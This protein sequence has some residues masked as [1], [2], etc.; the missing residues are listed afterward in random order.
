M[1]F[2]SIPISLLLL[3]SPLAAEPLFNQK[4][5]GG[6]RGVGGEAKNWAVGD[7]GTLTCTGGAGAQWLATEKE[8]DDFDLS[9]EFKLPKNANSGVFVRAPGEGHPWVQGMEIQLL[10]DYGEKWKDLKPAQ[11][12]GSIYAV[13]APKERATKMAGEWQKLRVRCVGRSCKVWVNG[14]QVIDANLDKLAK[15]SGEKVPGL[16]RKSGMIGLQ[17]HGDPVSFRNIEI[18]EVKPTAG[19]TR[20]FDGKT[21]K[22]WRADPQSSADAWSVK[23]GV[24]RAEGKEARLAYLIY[25]GDENL[26][27]FELRFRYRMVTKGNTGVEVRSRVDKTGKR[28]LEG[29]HADLGHVGIG[30]AILGAWDFHFAKRKE[31]PCFRGSKL[32]IHEDGKTGTQSKIDGA[33]TLDE[34]KKHG[35]NDCRIVAKGQHLQ[36]YINGKL[37][38]EFIDNASEGK[39]ESGSI[40]IQLHDK[41]MIVEFKDI[42]L[43][44]AP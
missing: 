22:G 10:D 2:S 31:F 35:W 28:P 5:L 8:Y 32:V 18:T 12:T 14:K 44:K 36:F 4:D 9:L 21:L 24:M 7:D 33:I 23:D 19:F 42:F 25:S 16:N 41:G 17:N 26:R 29:Y 43:R 27:D 1:N 3:I 38:S 30:P 37:A 15:I 40:G 39:L 13:Q 6:W 34:I 20:I 11:F